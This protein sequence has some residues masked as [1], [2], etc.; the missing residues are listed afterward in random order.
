[1][2]VNVAT[3][4]KY[5]AIA[6]PDL[7]ECVPISSGSKPSTSSPMSL[8]AARSFSSIVAEEMVDSLLSTKIVLTLVSDVVPGYDSMRRTM[9]A[10]ALTGHSTVSPERCIVM[11]SCLSSLFWN[12]KVIETVSARASER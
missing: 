7:M 4:A 9:A 12:S 1:M 2:I 5:I 10:H 8:A 6:A 3:S 11:V